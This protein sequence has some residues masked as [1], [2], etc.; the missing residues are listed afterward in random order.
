MAAPRFVAC[1]NDDDDGAATA[2][3]D[4]EEDAPK[5]TTGSPKVVGTAGG[6]ANMAAESGGG[7]PSGRGR[8]ASREE[9]GKVESAVALASNNGLRLSAARRRSMRRRVASKR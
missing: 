4:A 1:V 9:A 2:F 5:R 3:G 6:A 7:G 8:I